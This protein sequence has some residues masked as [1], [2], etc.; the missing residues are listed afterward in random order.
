[1]EVKSGAL[2]SAKNRKAVTLVAPCVTLDLGPGGRHS[3]EQRT[4][5]SDPDVAIDTIQVSLKMCSD[6]FWSINFGKR[7]FAAN[8]RFL[9]LGEVHLSVPLSVASGESDARFTRADW[10][11]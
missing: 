8:S 10:K 6:C 5:T 2:A 1:M 11:I 7:C 4:A 9:T 3:Y